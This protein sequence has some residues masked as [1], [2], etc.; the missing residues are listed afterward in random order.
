MTSFGRHNS[1]IADLYNIEIAV[2][3]TLGSDAKR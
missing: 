2:V 1:T 3:L